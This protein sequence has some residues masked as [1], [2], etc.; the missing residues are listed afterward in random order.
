MPP[1]PVSPAMRRRREEAGLPPAE[2]PRLN[3]TT[4]T[5]PVF[6]FS[7]DDDD[8]P[9]SPTPPKVVYQNTDH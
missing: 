2:E 8:K 6:T 7:G 5:T 3:P 9:E 1:R 4:Q